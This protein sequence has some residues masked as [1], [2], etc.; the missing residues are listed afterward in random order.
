MNS[1]QQHFIGTA[2]SV[3][4]GIDSGP[5]NFSLAIAAIDS[6]NVFCHFYAIKARIK[7]KSDIHS[8]K[9][10]KRRGK[11]FLVTLEDSIWSLRVTGF[12]ECVDKFHDRS[13]VRN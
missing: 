4:C 13:E 9:N 8:W 10:E 6:R 3:K 12:N 1:T 5:P 2:D 7:K 11:L